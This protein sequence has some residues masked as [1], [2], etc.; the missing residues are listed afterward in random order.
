VNG[1][2]KPDVVLLD[3]GDAGEH[4][5]TALLNDGTGDSGARSFSAPA[6]RKLDLRRRLHTWD[7]VTILGFQSRGAGGLPDRPDRSK[8]VHKYGIC[9]H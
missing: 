5:I 9:V 7:N 2:G 4:F 1:D 3:E 6:F 8:H